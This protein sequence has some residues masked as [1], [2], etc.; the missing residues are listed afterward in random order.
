MHALSLGDTKLA[1]SN[2]NAALSLRCGQNPTT[3][4]SY[5]QTIQMNQIEGKGKF[6]NLSRFWRLLYMVTCVS[7][8]RRSQVNVL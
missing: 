5:F 1:E 6:Q 7:F 3:L 4:Q 2:F 8:G